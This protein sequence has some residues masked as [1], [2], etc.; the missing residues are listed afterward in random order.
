[1]LYKRLF[2]GMFAC[3]IY[4]SPEYYEIQYLPIE[5]EAKKI[6]LNI[7]GMPVNNAWYDI[8]DNTINISVYT[9]EQ[10]LKLY[11]FT[12][13]ELLEKIGDSICLD[14]YVAILNNSELR[15]KGNNFWKNYWKK[16]C[17]I[18]E[19]ENGIFHLEW[20]LEQIFKYYN[21]KNMLQGFELIFRHEMIHWNVKHFKKEVKEKRIKKIREKMFYIIDKLGFGKTFEYLQKY[22]MA[23][24]LWCE[25]IYADIIAIDMSLSE[26]EK[27]NQ[28]SENI[29]K[30]FIAT[31]VYYT[32]LRAEEVRNINTIMVQSTHP[33]TLVREATVFCL[34]AETNKMSVEKFAVQVAGAWTMIREIYEMIFRDI[35]VEENERFKNN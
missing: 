25:E 28:K 27:T 8:K 13:V 29:K 7:V 23:I 11:N 15:K 5:N 35:M 34:L 22:K 16:E 1:M 24:D 32:L 33:P 9:I 20:S 21:K 2:A 14:D 31:A 10:T 18:Y 26:C 3:Q 19:D 30:V 17:R 4:F 6:N 12:K